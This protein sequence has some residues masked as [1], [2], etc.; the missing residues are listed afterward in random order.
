MFCKDLE[1][2]YQ[3]AN[4]TLEEAGR[5]ILHVLNMLIN[6]DDLNNNLVNYEKTKHR[7]QES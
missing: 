1:V 4:I 7:T 2:E 6:E 3:Q 5:R